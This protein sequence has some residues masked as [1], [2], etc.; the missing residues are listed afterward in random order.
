MFHTIST[1]LVLFPAGNGGMTGQVK[2][3]EG[4]V[5]DCTTVTKDGDGTGTIKQ[6]DRKDTISGCA[7][8][9]CSQGRHGDSEILE[10]KTLPTG[11]KGGRVVEFIKIFSREAT[12]KTGVPFESQSRRP[13]VGARDHA[14]AGTASTDQEENGKSGEASSTPRTVCYHQ[15]SFPFTLRV[16]T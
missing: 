4:L 6:E 1:L 16:G 9:A 14:S 3:E 5:K 8:N 7:Q 11:A 15:T 13:T 2:K 12:Q 10:A